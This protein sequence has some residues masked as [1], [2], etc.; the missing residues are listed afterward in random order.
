MLAIDR[1]PEPNAFW[2]EDAQGKEMYWN[3][4]SSSF[5]QNWTEMHSKNLLVQY[6]IHYHN[7][8][9]NQDHWVVRFLK[10]A[11]KK[12]PSNWNAHNSVKFENG[13]NHSYWLVKYL[14]EHRK[15]NFWQAGIVAS[16]MCSRC[17]NICE[18]EMNN[19]INNKVH[20]NGVCCSYCKFVDP[21]Y[22]EARRVRLCYRACKNNISVKNIWD[23]NAP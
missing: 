14:V 18:A 10:W 22:L 19:T 12:L 21:G 13:I 11:L 6:S 20:E 4:Y 23:S 5:P 1:I 7:P 3:P 8:K 15:F 17:Q 2:F 16:E 9:R